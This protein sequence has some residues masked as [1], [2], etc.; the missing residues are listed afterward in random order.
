MSEQLK[1]FVSYR[2]EDCM[3]HAGRLAENLTWRAGAEVFL[4]VESIPLGVSFPEW[5][6]KEVARCDAMLVVIGNEWLTIVGQDGRPRI[7]DPA[8][9]VHIEIQSALERGVFTIPVLVRGAAMPRPEQLPHSISGLAHRNAAVLRDSSW[10]ADFDQLAEALS[11]LD[12]DD[13]P[14]AD[15]SFSWPGRFT[16]A[17]FAA[18]VPRLDAAQL[19]ALRSELYRRSWTDQEIED[20]ALV[21]A[22]ETPGNSSAGPPSAET[23][24]WPKRFT[25]AWFAANAPRFDAAELAALLAELRL[26]TWND[27]EIEDRVLVHARDA[28]RDLSPRPSSRAPSR[29]PA[30]RPQHNE[31][32]QTGTTTVDESD[33]VARATLAAAADLEAL[34]QANGRVRER[35]VADALGRHLESA[36][37]ERKLRIP[38]W[39]PQPGNVDIFTTDWLGRPKLVVETKHKDGDDVYECLWDLAKVLSLTTERSVEGAY[40]VT[41]TTAANWAR[42]V[43]CAELFETGRHN[44]VGAIRRYTTLWEDLL[45]EGRGRPLAVPETIDVSLVARVPVVL[46][47]LAWELRAVRVRAVEADW[48]GF[49]DGRPPPA[50]G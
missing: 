32:P 11:A 34:D 26:R 43:S 38:G 4:D 46:K 40:L 17:W 27:Q 5:I 25:D 23:T 12:R 16:D 6:D 42:P 37:V 30:A 1:I 15:S 49:I 28:N 50:E 18:N 14:G 24:R 33:P 21:H 48:T 22:R 35:Q 36:R 2:R 10:K 19:A 39:D 41:G 31:T 45:Q 29:S 13:D 3:I 20:R 7:E 8:D 47:G 44:L 9:W